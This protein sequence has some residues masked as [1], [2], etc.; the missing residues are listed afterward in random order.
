MI[1]PAE[2]EGNT[3]RAICESTEAVSLG[4]A[5]IFTAS[6]E[7]PRKK[8]I[9]TAPMASSVRAAF[10]ACGGRKAVTPFEID[11]VPVNATAPEENALRITNTVTLPIPAGTGCGTVAWGQPV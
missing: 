4:R 3:A 2:P 7:T 9:A 8:V 5:S 1:E 6:A 10:C 11:S